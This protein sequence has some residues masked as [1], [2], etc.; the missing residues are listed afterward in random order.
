MTLD[1][2]ATK[3][4]IWKAYSLYKKDINQLHLAEVKRL[5]E[6]RKKIQEQEER[7]AARKVA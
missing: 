1:C 5:E 4:P 6:A 7:K 3:P 2:F